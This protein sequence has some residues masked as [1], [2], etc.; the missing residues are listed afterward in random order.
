QQAN[1]PLAVRSIHAVDGT[2][3]RVPDVVPSP[4]RRGPCRWRAVVARTLITDA[5]VVTVN[6]RDEV[7]SPADLLIQDDRIAYLG[8]ANPELRSQPCD[9]RIDGSERVVIP[10][11]INAHTHTYNT[12][13][14]GGFEQSWLDLWLL[15]VRAPTAHLTAE[16]LYLSS[17]VSGTEMLHTGTTTT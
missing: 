14:K 17:L 9:E 4:W 7:L 11:L 13:L 1:R 12:L 6:P 2:P 5:T 8:P 16:Q 10:G 15:L 3:R